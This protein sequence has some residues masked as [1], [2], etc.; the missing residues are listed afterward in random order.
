MK[1]RATGVAAPQL[2]LLLGDDDEADA[3]DDAAAR[4]LLVHRTLTAAGA[5]GQPLSLAHSVSTL[6]PARHHAPGHRCCR[7]FLCHRESA[8][9]DSPRG[10]HVC[11]GRR[12]QFAG[13]QQSA[14]D[15]SRPP[16]ATHSRDDAAIIAAGTQHPLSLSVSPSASRSPSHLESR[17][18]RVKLLVD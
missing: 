4:D 15:S 11:E 14:D 18:N 1:G 9:R 6:F 10:R 8:E 7:R 12:F 2:L 13:E 16:E 5:R 3:R 17:N